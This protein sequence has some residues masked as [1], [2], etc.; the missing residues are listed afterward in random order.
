MTRERFSEDHLKSKGYSQQ[1]DGSW[2]KLP[3]GRMDCVDTK[4]HGKQE[5]A[6]ERKTQAARSRKV[7]SK[8]SPHPIAPQYIVTMTA[9]LRTLMD[10]D[11][12]ATA[13]KPVQDELAEHLHCDDGD[14]SIR[15]QVGQVETRGAEGVSVTIEPIRKEDNE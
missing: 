5:G 11:N 7:R 6:L 15:W 12:L 13:L 1:P 14:G 2:V 3:N 4:K 9:H 8:A 10:W